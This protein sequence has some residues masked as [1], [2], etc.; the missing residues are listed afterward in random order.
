MKIP[1]TIGGHAL[2]RVIGINPLSL[3]EIIDADQALGLDRTAIVYA[4]ID[5]GVTDERLISIANERNHKLQIVGFNPGD[6]PSCWLDEEVAECHANL[7]DVA[8]FVAKAVNAGV[9]EPLIIG[10]T[11][12]HHGQ[13][14]PGNFNNV[15][16]D[17]HYEGLNAIGDMF[18]VDIA[19]EGLNGTEEKIRHPFERIA[20]AAKKYPRIG[21]HFDIAHWHS[22]LF[23]A[24]GIA[25]IAEDIRFFEITNVERWPLSVD[26]GIDFTAYFAAMELLE[27]DC[28]IGLEPFCQAVIKAFELTE[29]CKTTY[30]GPETIESDVQF[31]KS[32]GIMVPAKFAAAA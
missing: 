6:G 16:N 13:E 19:C 27:D 23:T 29:L 3:A 7:G 4:L 24:D 20:D 11:Q 28:L 30:D 18:D 15:V 2:S 21:I 17:R 25:A 1:R 26:K 31:V 10:P 14:L 8:G 22:R 9:S 12:T 5:D 32:N